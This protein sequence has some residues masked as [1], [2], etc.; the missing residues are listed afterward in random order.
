MK[1]GEALEPLP[2]VNRITK[3]PN[4]SLSSL[5]ISRT[6]TDYEAHSNTKFDNYQYNS[7]RKLQLSEIKT[8]QQIC[9]LGRSLKNTQLAYSRLSPKLAG[10]LLTPITDLCF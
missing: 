4:N 6:E 3:L 9:E 7:F 2:T 10:F 1:T 5:I 8:T